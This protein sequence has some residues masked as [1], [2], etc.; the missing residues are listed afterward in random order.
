M[1]GAFRSTQ[2]TIL[3]RQRSLPGDLFS[4]HQP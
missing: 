3:A 2:K 4:V 1:T